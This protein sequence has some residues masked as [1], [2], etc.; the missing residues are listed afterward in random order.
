M[1]TFQKARLLI[2]AAML[3]IAPA[4]HAQTASL[5]QGQ[6]AVLLAQRLGFAL[7]TTRTLTEVEAVRLLT[8]N[9]ISPFGGWQIEEPLFENDLARILVYAMGKEGEIPEEER[10][11]PQTT[12][13]QDFLIREYDL[14]IT[15]SEIP[16]EALDLERGNRNIQGTAGDVVSSDPLLSD[17]LGGDPSQIS[18][19]VLGTTFLPVSEANLQAALAALTPSPG[20]GPA[21]RPSQQVQDTTPSTP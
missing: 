1:C 4:L 8:E 17:A 13:F 18:P 7:Q 9:N 11:D 14:E 21:G 12:A 16:P 6:A 5:S 15:G 19:T 20:T 2:L 3:T 10:D